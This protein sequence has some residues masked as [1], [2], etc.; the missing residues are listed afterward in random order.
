MRAL[1]YMASRDKV[2]VDA[3]HKGIQYLLI[4]PLPEL[5]VLV[6]ITKRHVVSGYEID[7]SLHPSIKSS[8]LLRKL[9]ETSG[10]RKFRYRYDFE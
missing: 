2:D 1:V 5:R 9:D 6:L 4:I 7:Q 10:S 3:F 8:L